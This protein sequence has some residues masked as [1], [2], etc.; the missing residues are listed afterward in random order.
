MEPFCNQ[1][2][3]T[4]DK[5][6]SIPGMYQVMQTAANSV[7]FTEIIKFYS[8]NHKE[9]A[10]SPSTLRKI[11]GHDSAKTEKFTSTHQNLSTIKAPL[12]RKADLWLPKNVVA[13]IDLHVKD[14]CY[15]NYKNITELIFKLS[16]ICETDLHT[17]RAI[18]KYVLLTQLE[19]FRRNNTGSLIMRNFDIGIE[20]TNTIFGRLC[21][22]AGIENHFVRGLWK[23]I[24]QEPGE[25]VE[26]KCVW[27]IVNLESGW[28]FMQ[29]AFTPIK[30][31]SRPDSVS[32]EETEFYFLSDPDYLF[33][34]FLPNDKLHLTFVRSTCS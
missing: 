3:T 7:N 13:A 6:H 24:C 15:V 14:A 4:V 12:Q 17:I 11:L 22:F 30:L 31:Y 33:Y 27:N 29:P 26:A 1:Y 5:L 8:Q 34:E 23:T 18:Y 19:G 9:V 16:E 32:Y 10:N 25:K 2:Q 20:S 21:S 28:R